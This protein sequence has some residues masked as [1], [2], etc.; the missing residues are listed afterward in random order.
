MAKYYRKLKKQVLDLPINKRIIFISD[1]HGNYDLFSKLLKKI[2]FNSNDYLF[3]LGDIFEKGNNNLKTLRYVMELTKSSHVYPLMGNCDDIYFRDIVNI[4]SEEM[5]LNYALVK[6][7]SVIN[8]MAEEL[9]IIITKDSNVKELCQ[10]F[11]KEYSS[12]IDYLD[13]LPHLIETP[14]FRC[15]H[16]G[17]I[18]ENDD[19]AYDL[20]HVADFLK[21][22]KLFDKYI[23][24]GHYPVINYQN[25]IP[26]FNPIID[27]VKK[28]ISIDG[29]NN[30]NPYG[31][32]NA[33]IL[34]SIES[35][36]FYYEYLDDFP[37]INVKLTTNPNNENSI[38]IT[39]HDNQIEII[40]KKEDY[41]V[42]KHL[43][44]GKILNV[45]NS[46]IYFKN[47]HYHC[48]FGTDYQLKVNK[49]DKVS[50]LNKSKEF[51]LVKK[52]GIV[53]YI[54]N[55]FV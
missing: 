45:F 15:V 37:T 43:S 41:S 29:G 11:T 17:I 34:E 14:Y 3:L 39:H 12:I 9:N 23:I 55:I 19:N 26:S 51:S 36:N 52:D 8:E 53:G 40:D 25:Q 33:L 21:T 35:M 50:L 22:N 38:N 6:G 47:N 46:D 28:I 49:N 13:T 32:L 5:F 20:M 27:K 31:Q 4:R 7:H 10:I 42:C 1:I 16:A 30:V 48:H 24:V 44:S 18:D 2:Y 54:P